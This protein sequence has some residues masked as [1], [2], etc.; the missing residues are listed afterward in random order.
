MWS[1]RT[2]LLEQALRDILEVDGEALSARWRRLQAWLSQRF[3][4]DA[5]I[6]GI[7]FLVGVQELGRGYA[8]GLNK[9]AKEQL[10]ME[11]T[12]C[13]YET[14]GFYERIGMEAD[15]HWIWEERLAPPPDLSE[16]EQETLLRSAVLR[17]FDNHL[18][19]LSD[20]P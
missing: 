8:P 11:G 20:E 6:E 19:N 5:D 15:G 3:G 7:L 14:L 1:P 2:T 4:R 10:V 16:D 13:V 17:Y 12:Y 9:G 18:G